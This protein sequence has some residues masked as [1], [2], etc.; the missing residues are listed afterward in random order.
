MP[1]IKQGKAVD[2]TWRRIASDA[3]ALL[4]GD[5]PAGDIIVPSG[6][7]AAACQRVHQGRIGVTI[8]NDL[9]FEALIGLIGQV[10]LISVNFPSFADGR[11]FSV[12]KRLRKAGFGGVLRAEG[13]LIADQAA[14]AEACGFDEIE[15]PDA[16][17]SRQP[18]SDFAD[19]RQAFPQT[20][21]EG[22]TA[23]REGGS[24]LKRRH[25]Q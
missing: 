20:Y 7:L 21:Q 6:R 19:A 2:D 10:D 8:D 15:I 4:D 22:F 11:G 12:A 24:I 9:D 16:L 17:A 13:P 23:P 3:D 5:L 14:F 1:L 18:V 25:F